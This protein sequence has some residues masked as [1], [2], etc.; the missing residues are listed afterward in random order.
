MIR[1]LMIRGLMIRGLMIRDLVVGGLMASCRS[2]RYPP[3]RGWIASGWPH[4]QFRRHGSLLPLTHIVGVELVCA[5]R[6]T[7]PPV[8]L[9]G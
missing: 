7:A 8:S 5:S 2:P 6:Q 1:G 4:I 9:N 3:R